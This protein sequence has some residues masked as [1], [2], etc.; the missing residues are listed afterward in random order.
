MNLMF[1]CRV[2]G[3]GPTLSPRKWHRGDV[4]LHH[5]ALYIY[6]RSSIHSLA[7][8]QQPNAFP[9]ASAFHAYVTVHC[10]LHGEHVVRSFV[11]PAT[12][13]RVTDC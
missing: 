7:V 5:T 2:V 4:P 10:R 9:L 8:V 11:T 12:T 1:E 6:R 13:G 3:I